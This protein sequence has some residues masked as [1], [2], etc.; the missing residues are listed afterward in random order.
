MTPTGGNLTT[1]M[2]TS[3][4]NGYAG[5]TDWLCGGGGFTLSAH[6]TLNHSYTDGYTTN[7]KRAVWVHEFGHALGLNH[8]ASNYY[9]MYTCPRC[10]YDAHGI[11]TPQSDDINGANH[12]Y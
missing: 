12:L 11:F 6:A 2:T 3:G 9:I 4:L 10:A 1:G 5:W 8:A 7:Q